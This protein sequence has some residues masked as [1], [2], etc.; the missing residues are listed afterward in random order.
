[1]KRGVKTLVSAAAAAVLLTSMAACSN[2]NS[3]TPAPSGGETGG[4][5][6]AST[7]HS[8]GPIDIWYSTNEQEIEW[9][10]GVVEAWNAEH[11]DQKVTAQAIPA[12][13][14]SEDV[15]T[16]SITAG[17]APCLVYNTAP[18]AVPM[19]QKQGGLVN[20]SKTFE[21]ANQFIA[22][23]SGKA[24][25]GFKSADGDYYQM[26]WKTNPFMLYYNK[27]VLAAAGF[28]AENPKLETYE[29]MLALG[30]AVKDSGAAQ[31]LIYPPST[32]DFTNVNFDFYPF[33]LAN[34][35]GK[36]FIADGKATFN[37]PEGIETLEFWQKIY[38]EGYSSPEAYGGDMWAGPFADGVAATGVAGPWGKGQFDGKVEFDVVPIPTK[39]GKAADQTYTF[40]DSK[41]VGMY[42]SCQNLQTAWDFLKFSMNDDSD[43]SLLEITGQFPT[44]TDVT[45][46][47][48]TFLE[49]NP[50]FV[51]FAEA[52]PLAVDVPTIDGLAERMQ[53]F[54]DAWTGTVQSG[55]GDITQVFDQ[56]AKQVDEVQ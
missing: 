38:A 22:D 30:A 15:I 10:E 32:A 49:E 35:G 1:M 25:E 12:G 46:L 39:G 21:D 50:F 29:D 6:N 55:T 33:F 18:S 28:D 51:P 40:A 54:R 4:D 47:A 20:L 36:Q 7:E 19:F 24:A 8:A 17:N 16:A 52:V 14:S 53:I 37:D 5:E 45:T 23:R 41:N 48:A 43:L 42:T 11:P 2:N 13:S 26:P 31:Y 44:R 27:T 3:Q 56:A 34:S 9:G